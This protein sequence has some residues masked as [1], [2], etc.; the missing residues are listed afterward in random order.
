MTDKL[1]FKNGRRI[2]ISGKLLLETLIL[3]SVLL[4]IVGVF[5]IVGKSKACAPEPPVA[6]LTAETSK[7][8]VDVNIILDGSN[9]EDTD[10]TI[11]KYEWDFENDGV[12]D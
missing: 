6:V 8:P 5:F 12:Y 1:L 11:V 2:R 3:I 10:G 4:F 7:I 9:S